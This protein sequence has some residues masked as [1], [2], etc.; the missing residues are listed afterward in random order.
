MMKSC[1]RFKARFVPPWER[2][3]QTHEADSDERSRIGENRPAAT[4]SIAEAAATESAPADNHFA[5]V[6]RSR[7]CAVEQMRRLSLG[8]HRRNDSAHQPHL[9]TPQEQPHAQATTLP[10]WDAYITKISDPMSPSPQLHPQHESERDEIIR[11]A[12]AAGRYSGA[13]ADMLRADMEMKLDFKYAAKDVAGGRAA[14]QSLRWPLHGTC[15]VVLDMDGVVTAGDTVIEGS[16][17]AIQHM[18]ELKI[19]FVFL[20]N[21]GG[22]T[23]E[24]RAAHVSKLLRLKEP[25]TPDQIILGHS[26]FRYVAPLYKDRPVLIIGPQP[27]SLEA[28][29]EYGFNCASSVYEVQVAHPELVPLKKFP[30][31]DLPVVEQNRAIARQKVINNEALD[32]PRFDAV[33]IFNDKHFDGLNDTQVIVDVLTAPYGQ[34]GPY[35]SKYQT[36]PLYMAADNLLWQA[37]VPEPRLGQGAVR[38]MI[39]AAFRCVTGEQLQVA[40]F[41]KPRRIAYAV[42]LDALK[43]ES[44]RLGWNPDELRTACM[45]GDDVETDVVG[46]NAAGW[47]WLSV[48]VL[49]GVARPAG[50]SLRTIH[51]D[52]AEAHWLQQHVSPTPQYVAPTLDHFIREMEHFGEAAVTG[53]QPK[54][55][56]APAVPF[57]IDLAELYHYPTSTAG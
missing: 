51:P 22:M 23:E 48:H 14:R 55:D 54:R 16:D 43:R 38:E 57:P 21:G 42:A 27:G 3:R 33:F 2:A 34:I 19:P 17:V 29:R 32:Y 1:R 18:Q 11:A 9:P 47:P 52:D 46:A 30:K 31:E 8:M 28:A 10:A 50:V 7:A 37:K 5:G 6:P 13:A 25:V 56:E 39:T 36:V 53:L 12:H 41:G 20:S 45:V 4:S 35:V 26:P 49:S 40:Q 24:T 15:G 44:E